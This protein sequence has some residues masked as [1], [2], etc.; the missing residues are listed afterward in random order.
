MRKLL[1]S[2]AAAGAATALAAPAGAQWY[3]RPV[4]GYGWGGMQNI[5]WRIDAVQRRIVSMANRGQIS[6]P[7]AD[8]LLYDT[9]E[10]EWDLRNGVN[11]YQAR[12]IQYRLNRIEQ[13][14]RYSAYGLY[15]YRGY[16][17]H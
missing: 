13:Q 14:L 3:P 1:L 8:R 4:Y 16:A 7:N 17:P 12:N 5:Q 15:G 9:R 10:L 11:P 6:P 2:L